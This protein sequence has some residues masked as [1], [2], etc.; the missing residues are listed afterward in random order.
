MRVV[1]FIEGPCCWDWR[2]PARLRE[3]VLGDAST[4]QAYSTSRF[5]D[6]SNPNVLSTIE[7]S[8]HAVDSAVSVEWLPPVLA[9]RWRN[10]GLQ[11]ASEADL[12]DMD[13][14]ET[15]VSSLDL[16]G[17][18][19]P[20]EGTVA[21]L[22]RSLHVLIA[23][24][25]D[26]DVSYSDPSLPLSVFVSCPLPAERNRVERLAENVVH[27]ALHLQLSLVERVQPLVID[28]PDEEPVFSPWKD[29][30]RTVRGL[31]HAVYVFG[32]L[33][34]FWKGVASKRPE[35]SSFAQARIQTIDTEMAGAA[36]LV[37]NQSL[38]A[39]GLRLAT[40]FLPSRSEAWSVGTNCD[41]VSVVM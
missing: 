27:E 3:R 32:N 24:C 13:F 35:S 15:F 8:G 12:S 40:S 21:G 5:L 28:G 19:R 33:R 25:R 37:N 16:I 20:L 4:W 41:E 22:C 26:F 23:S 18:D 38:T 34:N 10:V 14:R 2:A 31:V 39:A 17:M 29:E 6:G 36:H 1:E 30:W 7:F 11:F 9:A